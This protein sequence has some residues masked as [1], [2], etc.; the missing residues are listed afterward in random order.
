MIWLGFQSRRHR[1]TMTQRV[2][3]RIAG[4]PRASHGWS[5]GPAILTAEVSLAQEDDESD[6]HADRVF[7]GS[8]IV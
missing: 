3:R 4:R 2:H 7:Q 6:R 1:T 8:K 5:D